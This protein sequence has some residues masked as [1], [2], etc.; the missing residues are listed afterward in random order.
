MP[1]ILHNLLCTR[2]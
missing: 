1:Y 2:Y